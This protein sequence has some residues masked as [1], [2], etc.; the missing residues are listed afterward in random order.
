[1]ILLAELRKLSVLFLLIVCALPGPRLVAHSHDAASLSTEAYLDHLAQFH[2]DTCGSL[3][4]PDCPHYHWVFT[5]DDFRSQGVFPNSSQPCPP[6]LERDID[7]ATVALD[8]PCEVVDTVCETPT[9]RL[10]ERA[11]CLHDCNVAP[12]TERPRLCV[13]IC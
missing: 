12:P 1:M 8:I 7:L 3:I 13:W 6:V 5:W 10:T 4:A 9:V 2:A 11:V